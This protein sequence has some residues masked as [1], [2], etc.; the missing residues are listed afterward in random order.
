M[1]NLNVDD[2]C[3]DCQFFDAETYKYYTDGLAYYTSVSCVHSNICNNLY[4]RLKI[5]AK[6]EKCTFKDGV[7]IKPDG[8]NELDPCVYEVVET[9]KNVTVNVLKCK[10]CGHIEL[11][12]SENE[13]ML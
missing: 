11:E 12:W 7:T 13:E 10:K 3:H 1:I 9:H 6:E 2:Y 4:Q 5:R 8:V